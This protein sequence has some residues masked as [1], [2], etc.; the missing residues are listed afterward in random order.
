MKVCAVV[1]EFN[2]FHNGHKYLLSELRKGGFDTVVCI[3]SGNF[4]QRGEYAV[5]DKKIRAA[6]AVE[7]GA[8]LVL[9]LPFPWSCASAELFAS[10]AVSILNSLGCIDG[11]GFGTECG[12]IG[13]LG[14][15]ASFL[16]GC[17]RSV[18]TDLQKSDPKLSFAQARAILAQRELGDEACALFS[19]P[20]DILAIEYMK[21]LCKSNSQILYY[22]VKRE[23]ASHDGK[24]SSSE[25]CSSS[26]IRK[27]FDSGKLDEISDFVPWDS[28]A[29]KDKILKLDMMAYFNFL[30]GA[31]L[32]RKPEE[33]ANFAEN[34]GGF[35]YALYREMLVSKDYGTLFENLR[36]RHLTDAKIRRALLFTALGVKKEVFADN[37]EFTEV[38]S[39]ND[40]GKELLKQ[41]RKTSSISILSK[42]ANIKYASDKAKEQFKLQRTSEIAF[43][44]L[45]LNK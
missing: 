20:N 42:I 24:I 39:C 5:L 3:M 22:P 45:L 15:C 13:L 4:V 43:E 9:S 35:E 25:M 16:A 30:R 18:I 7:S 44:T 11:I 31:V 41:C 40:K 33:L 34:G 14:K 2:P 19:R 23:E 32:S 26:V 17:D 12:D 36:T 6:M 38:L 29:V 21:A 8:D 28:S 1:S 27:M 10:G 37:P